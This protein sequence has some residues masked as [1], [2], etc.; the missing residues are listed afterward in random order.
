LI[1]ISDAGRAANFIKPNLFQ[2][3]SQYVNADFNYSTWATWSKRIVPEEEATPTI[4]TDVTQNNCLVVSVD[5]GSIRASQINIAARYAT[6]DFAIIKQVTREYILALPNTA[7]DVTTEVYEAYNPTTNTY[8]FA[9][10][11]T[12]IAIPVPATDTDQFADYIYPA[13]AVEVLNGNLIA[14]GDLQVGYP[15]PT[16]AVQVDAVGYDPNVTIALSTTTDRL[17]VSYIN[18]G[19][20]GSGEGGHKRYVQVNFLGTPQANDKITVV[21][22]DIRNANATLSYTYTV[23]T[24]DTLLQAVGNLSGAI[25]SSSY[26]QDTASPQVILSIVTPPFYGLQNAYVTL[27]N[28]G[29]TVTKS[30]HGVLDNSSYQL[31]LSYRDKY[32]RPFPLV[33]G[34]DFIAKTPS[35]AQLKGGANQISWNILSSNA[36]VGAVDY[37]WLMTKKEGH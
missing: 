7:V 34:N 4:G 27:F 29:A 37:Q 32:G 15:R 23:L 2:F 13:N 20:S 26:R 3:T 14:I 9:F 17:R 16:T 24:G 35:F 10:Y 8:S 22:Q 6:L 5:I 36:P 21:L 33:T 28:A 1:I 18:S 12:D 19:S 30:V 11:N 25:P 31:A